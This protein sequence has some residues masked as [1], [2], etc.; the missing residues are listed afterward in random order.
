[1]LL[2][3]C[4]GIVYVLFLLRSCSVVQCVAVCCSAMVVCLCKNGVCIAAIVCG[5]GVAVRCSVLQCIVLRCSVLQCVTVRC[6]V[7]QCVAV[8]CSALQ[9]VAVCC[10]DCM[11]AVRCSAL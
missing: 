11:C 6:S 5:Q 10:C 8:H 2:L 9:C 4:A 3:I 7:L 1:M